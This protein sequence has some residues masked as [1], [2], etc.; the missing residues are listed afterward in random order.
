M[1]HKSAVN[2]NHIFFNQTKKNIISKS[3]WS[4]FEDPLS[5]R[6]SGHCPTLPLGSYTTDH[7]EYIVICVYVVLF[8]GTILL[9]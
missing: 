9:K 2:I 8:H 4:R 3:F 6:A 7:A 1:L 5:S